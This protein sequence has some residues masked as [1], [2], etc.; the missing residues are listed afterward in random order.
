MTTLGLGTYPVITLAMARE[1][2]LENARAIA[3]GR[4]P[5]RASHGGP[6]FARAA[7]TVLAIHAV[8]WKPGSRSEETWRASLRDY[9]LPRLGNMRVDAV[10]T[11][12]VMAVLLPIWS[13]KRETARRLR[14]RIGAVMK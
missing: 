12:D 11:S 6:T 7:E 8:N 4:D 13:T 2:A 3:Q 9:A 10:T 1:R 5:R 14:Q